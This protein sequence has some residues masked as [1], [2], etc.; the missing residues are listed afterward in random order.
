MNTNYFLD[1]VAGGV[2]QSPSASLPNEFYIGLSTTTPSADGTGVTE[3][4]SSA[5][6]KR[7]KL[8]SISEPAGGVVSNSSSITFDESTASWGVV[9]HFVIFDA[10]SGGNLLIFGELSSPR[11]VEADTIMA[12]KEG[13][14]K[15]SV[16]NPA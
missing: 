16:Q 6:Y 7:I 10:L 14:L 2:F 1:C 12:I 8:L 3:P 13:Y 9:T 11:T 15:L 4:S 5:G